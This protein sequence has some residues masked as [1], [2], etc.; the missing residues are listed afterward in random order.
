MNA[1]IEPIEAF[2]RS[3]DLNDFVSH[4][5]VHWDLHPGNLLVDGANLS[6]VVD[7]DFA[8]IGDAFFDLVMLT[9]MCLRPPLAEALAE[10]VVWQGV[11]PEL[12]CHGRDEVCGVLGSARGGQPPRVTHMEAEEAGDRVIVT[13]DGP[14]FGPG[15]AGSTLEP[16]GGPRTLVLSF[17]NSTVVRM[18]SFATPDEALGVATC[19]A[20]IMGAR[21][22]VRNEPS[23]RQ[24]LRLGRQGGAAQR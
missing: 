4:D 10:D 9:L 14:D 20:A 12:V 23:A 16:A 3:L 7:T 11:L 1:L 18:E 17:K 5:M 22:V 13:V 24:G 21:C 2:G 6:A 19:A 8:Q 15:P